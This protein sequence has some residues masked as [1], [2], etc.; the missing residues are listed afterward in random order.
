MESGRV[1][2]ELRERSVCIFV[3]YFRQILSDTVI[4]HKNFYFGI[5]VLKCGKIVI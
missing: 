3:K 1:R 5:F 2:E 4:S